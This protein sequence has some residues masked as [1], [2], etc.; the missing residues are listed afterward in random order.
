[1][2]NR[3]IQLDDRLQDY[4]LSVSLREPAVL[5]ELREHTMTLEMARMQI[6]PEQGQLMGLLLRLMGARRYLEV[7]TFTGYSALIA[8]LA[9]PDDAEVVA[10]D[11]SE[12]WTDIAREYW[13][14][15][16]VAERIQLRLGA[17]SDSLQTLVGQRPTSFDAVFVDADKSSYALYVQ[18]AFEL[19]RP[20]GLLMIDNVLWGGAVVDTDDD[21]EDTV[22]IRRINEAM[23]ADQRW[24][25]SLVPIGD[26]LTLAR[27]R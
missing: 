4:L 8:A 14:K 1:M 11:I 6:S 26:G 17:A 20:G 19:L 25:L 12:T 2:S 16:G 13:Q 18:H 27:K 24:D 10:L 22:A 5:A 3:T 21:D 23:L 7:G 9:M 15:A